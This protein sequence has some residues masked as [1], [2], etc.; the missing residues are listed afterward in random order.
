MAKVIDGGL[1]PEDDPI[2]SGSWMIH[3]HQ[4]SQRLTPDERRAMETPVTDEPKK[5]PKPLKKKK[6]QGKLMRRKRA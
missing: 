4:N 2:F 1:L 5:S 6:R 3:S